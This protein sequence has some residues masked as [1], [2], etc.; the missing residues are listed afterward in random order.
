MIRNAHVNGMFYPSNPERLAGVLH[1]MLE[2][3]GAPDKTDAPLGLVVPHAG[4][5]YSGA[6][7]A[8]AYRRISGHEYECIVIVSPS[9]R[10][11]F[12]FCSVFDGSAYATPLGTVPVNTGLRDELTAS[13][14][15]VIA[16]D[17]GHGE[18]HAIEVQLPFIQTVCG[19]ASILPIVI[20][21]QSTH[22]CRMLARALTDLAR[23]HSILIVASSDLSHFH[24]Y[25]TAEKLDAVAARCIEQL[26]GDHLLEA[27]DTG[28]TE[29]CGGGPVATLLL[30]ANRLGAGTCEVLHRCNSGDITH[31]R[32]RVVGYLSAA[33]YF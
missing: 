15:V 4:Y 22:H 11:Y 3:C 23:Q 20:G 31:E 12:D 24:T 27:L 25:E 2:R 28:K 14:P 5:Q 26:D 30:A 32:S 8:A 17:A 10:E 7:A 21:N 1:S 18:E 33:I 16:S 6:T 9:H 29:A 19:N 13:S